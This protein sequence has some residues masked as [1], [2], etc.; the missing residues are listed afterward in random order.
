[1]FK[2]TL[3]KTLVG[4]E[5]GH[6]LLQVIH[7][8]NIFRFADPSTS[9]CAQVEKKIEEALE[10]KHCLL[11]TNCTS[12]L[13][14]ALIALEPQPGDY[15]LI[16]SISFIATASAC[17]NVGLIPIM[18][19]VDNS[20]HL[21][22]KILKNFLITHE[23]PFAVIAVHLDGA[24][25]DIE[26]IATI[27]KE[28]EVPLIED[29][30]RA[31][32]VTQ[33]GKFLG[34]F[35]DIGCFSFQENKILSTGEGG[36]LVT[37][38]SLLFDKVKAYSDHG[39]TRDFNGHPK[40]EKNLGFGENFKC[41]ELTAAVL[42]A[43]LDKR[44]YI[45]KQLRKHYDLLIQEFPQGAIHQR[46]YEDIPTVVWIDSLEVQEHLK[47]LG[48]PLKSWNLWFLPNHPS[49]KEKRSFY[50]N[51]YPWNLLKLNHLPKCDNG[52]RISLIRKNLPIP[53]KDEDFNILYNRISNSLSLI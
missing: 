30:A 47:G 45:S 38:N 32:S 46:N 13:K 26:Q 24:G 9:I 8:Q 25:C 37:E 23:K 39:A 18:L 43:Q 12:A 6:N 14:S 31:F 7:S 2:G 15:V 49:I 21:D 52:E 35:G 40:W 4:Q 44:N 11:L 5:E 53:V 36:A 33:N 19:D 17:L 28:H 50:R 51:S 27:C 10:V 41:N 29:A 22:P 34:T 3:G 1:M 20:G 16:P 42:L 48:I